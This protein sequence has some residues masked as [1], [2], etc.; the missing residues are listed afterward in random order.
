[1]NNIIKYKLLRTNRKNI[2]IYIKDGMVEIKAP[3]KSSILD[4]ENFLNIKKQLILENLQKSI[5]Q[6]QNRESFSLDYG[7]YIRLYGNKHQIIKSE[8]D[9]SKFENDF[10]YL[11][12]NLNSEQIK[13]ECIKI[14]I[15]IAK[16]TLSRQTAIFAY[17]MNLYPNSIKINKA[18]KRWGSCSSKKSINF[19][20]KLV[21]ANFDTIDYVVVHELAH[22]KEMNHSTKFWDIVKNT[23]PDYKKRIEDLRSL[24]EK[25]IKENW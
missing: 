22:L 7:S 8:T 23:L 24:E 11:P 10:F 2:G 13:E 3:Y 21:M 17:K 14:Y 5:I 1:M 12:K 19:S 18:A 6:K 15:D 16:M 9:K 25:L 4:I 20:F